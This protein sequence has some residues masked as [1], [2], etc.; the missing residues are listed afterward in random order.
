MNDKRLTKLKDTQA[1][2]S[3]DTPFGYRDYFLIT[4]EKDMGK[5]KI[6]ID[7]IDIDFCLP[8][9]KELKVDFSNRTTTAYCAPGHSFRK[10]WKE[11]ILKMQ[12]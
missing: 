5:W 6:E 1:I 10:W 4:A 2:L 12:I 8:L 11:L 3:Q 7:D 9:I